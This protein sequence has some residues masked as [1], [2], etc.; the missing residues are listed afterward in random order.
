MGNMQ[1]ERSR[2]ESKLLDCGPQ[3]ST[4]CFLT[5]P[6]Y[7]AIIHHKTFQRLFDIPFM[8]LLHHVEG[9]CSAESRGEHSVRVALL[10]YS[11]SRRRQLPKNQER[12]LVTSALL[13]DLSHPPFSHTLEFALKKLAGFVPEKKLDQLI[14]AND[15][16]EESLETILSKFQIRKH[17]LPIFWPKMQRPAIFSA[18]HNVDTLEGITRSHRFFTG[19]KESANRSTD[20]ALGLPWKILDVLDTCGQSREGEPSH[21]VDL[22]DHF[23]AM[24][25]NVYYRNIYDRRRVVLERISSYYLYDLCKK[26]R[27]QNNIF[28]ISDENIFSMFPSLRNRL[29]QLWAYVSNA[30]FD[31]RD[32][33]GECG[34]YLF[35]TRRF[36]ID[37]RKPL[38]KKIRISSLQSRYR[39]RPCKFVVSFSRRFR[40]DVADI[41]SYPSLESRLSLNAMPADH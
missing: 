17:D 38:S 14:S 41:L 32:P 37:T 30:S 35:E 34:K 8:G 10:T 27:I 22:L 26:E 7:E 20:Q 24:K 19:G 11:F 25:N 33:S 9:G 3:T 23:W 6:L 29:R 15:E 21:F 31:D 12:V 39:V 40:S 28:M 5:D 13:H 1:F 36:F 2:A 4:R 16:L 18:T